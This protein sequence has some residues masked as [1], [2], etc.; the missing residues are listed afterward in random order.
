MSTAKDRRDSWF[1]VPAVIFEDE[2]YADVVSDPRRGW[3][4]IRM[5]HDADRIWPGHPSLPRW[6][7]Q[8]ALDAMVGTG[9]VV[10]LPNDTYSI[11]HLD[12]RRSKVFE[13]ASENGKDSAAGAV[14]DEAGHFAPRTN[15]TPVGGGAPTPV[16]DYPTPVGFSAPTPPPTTKTKTK[17]ETPSSPAGDSGLSTGS[18]LDLAVELHRLPSGGLTPFEGKTSA[19]PGND[20]PRREGSDEGEP[21]EN[22]LCY[23]CHKPATLDNPLIQT[24]AGPHHKN[25]C[26]GL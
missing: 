1:A 7:D 26:P 25:I 17:T 24:P 4:W 8:P 14:R 5:C 23:G 12:A 22:S 10:V 2:R 21:P 15:P 13:D 3:G 20:V 9:L 6:L 19:P 18:A 16:G 11:P